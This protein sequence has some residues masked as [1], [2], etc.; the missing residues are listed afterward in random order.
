[1]KITI[2]SRMS[3]DPRGRNPLE[4]AALAAGADHARVQVGDDQLVTL[5][6]HGPAASFSLPAEATL[7]LDH[8][9]N[10]RKSYAPVPVTFDLGESDCYVAAALA[11][12]YN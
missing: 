4:L 10:G 3:H 9:R 6:G 2:T 12:R 5:R 8:W 7:W 11:V 1:M